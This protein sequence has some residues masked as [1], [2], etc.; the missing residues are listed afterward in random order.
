MA[1][2]AKGTSMLRRKADEVK[3]YRTYQRIIPRVLAVIAALLLLVYVVALMYTRY[4][5]FTVTVNKYHSLQYGLALSETPD[6][7]KPTALLECR[8]AEEITNIDGKYLTDLDLGAIDGADSGENYLC[9]TFYCKN[10]GVEPIEFEYAIN[11]AN[12]TLGIEEACRIRLMTSKNGKDFKVVDYA[13]AAGVDENGQAVPEPNT[14][15]F[16]DKYTVMKATETDFYPGDLCK[17]TVVIW[18]E[19]NDPQCIDPIIGGEFKVDMN[20]KV[21]KVAE[22]DV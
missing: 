17:Y 16:F 6:F 13:R 9:Y 8:A 20:F 19:G 2:A 18:L 12:M 1:I 14:T 15:P 7:G 10:T 3:R 5:S 11:I 21:T 22:V 4:G